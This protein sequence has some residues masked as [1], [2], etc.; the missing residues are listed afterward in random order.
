MARFSDELINR[1]KQDISLVRVV[2]ARGIKLK[3]QGKDYLAHCPFHNDKTPSFV[4]SPSSNLW[5]CL[6]ACG[7][8][9][10]VIDF[11]M[12]YEGVSFRHAVELL[13]DDNALAE[14]SS[15]AA[16]KPLKRPTVPKLAAPIEANADDPRYARWWITITKR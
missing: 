12:K 9:G 6:G 11:V 1:I 10:S 16:N 7:C 4:I 15:L 8:G 14:S 5:N 13:R 2:E 3:K